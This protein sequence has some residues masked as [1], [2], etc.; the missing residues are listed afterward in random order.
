MSS[1]P[2]LTDHDLAILAEALGDSSDQHQEGLTTLK[3]KY[4]SLVLS[5]LYLSLS[6]NCLVAGYNKRVRRGES[7]VLYQFFHG[8]MPAIVDFDS[9]D[10]LFKS[11]SAF[12]D[13]RDVWDVDDIKE[14]FTAASNMLGR[15]KKTLKDWSRLLGV[16]QPVEEY[17]DVGSKLL[18]TAEIKKFLQLVTD[19]QD[20]NTDSELIPEFEGK[21]TIKNFKPSI[22]VCSSSG[23]GKTQLPF[24][25][26]SKVPLLY[27]LDLQDSSQRTLL[28][29]VYRPFTDI[30]L[31]FN[32]CCK[33]DRELLAT[34]QKLLNATK[35]LFSTSSTS[36]IGIQRP[37]SVSSTGSQQ[38]SVA[39][40][41]PVTLAESLEMKNDYFGMHV[42]TEI[43]RLDIKLHSVS[44]LEIVLRRM[45]DVRSG[46]GSSWIDC[47]LAIQIPTLEECF[48]KSIKE[49]SESI[50]RTFEIIGQLPIIFL[51]ECKTGR[52]EYMYAFKRNVIRMMNLIPVVM[53]TDT[54]IRNV[55]SSFSDADACS[56]AYGDAW[57]FVFSK[58]PNYSESLLELDINK[59]HN[60]LSHFDD[61]PLIEGRKRLVDMVK[62]VLV[63]ERPLFVKLILQD[64]RQMIICGSSLEEIIQSSLDF[65][66]STFVI[67]KKVTTE[68]LHS[69]AY[70][71]QKNYQCVDDKERSRIG[72]NMIHRHLGSL[73]YPKDKDLEKY[74]GILTLTVNDS[75][76]SLTYVRPRNKF[77]DF[78]PFGEFASF[79]DQ[80][81]S[82]LAFLSSHPKYPRPSLPG[83]SSCSLRRSALDVA[84]EIKLGEKNT[85]SAKNQRDGSHLEALVKC[86]LVFSLSRNGFKGQSA[87]EWLPWFASEYSSAYT[88][89]EFV[90]ESEELKSALSNIKLPFIGREDEEWNKDLKDFIEEYCEAE[91]GILKATSNPEGID[92]KILDLND[93]THTILRL[94]CKNWGKNVSKTDLAKIFW[95]LLRERCRLNLVVAYT[96]ED[97]AA[98]PPVFHKHEIEEN[99]IK[100]EKTFDDQNIVV[101]QVEMMAPP[102]KRTEAGLKQVK[103]KILYGKL[104]ADC[105]FFFVWP[106][107][108]FECL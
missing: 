54:K 59:L 94:E 84:D 99:D 88:P 74:K 76:L 98:M 33:K 82:H 40:Q 9:V 10:R 70:F 92:G 35:L 15:L 37:S 100:V 69:Q 25:I 83:N 79:E 43:A 23:M 73:E 78:H 96:F 7:E 72:S 22:F 65:I 5:E 17:E 38:L 71:A 81:F 47:E 12:K 61:L 13:L 34:N 68:F 87:V 32:D 105:R 18:E 31:V 19:V 89:F 104:T 80:P 66:F 28:Q 2:P 58:L 103:I 67:L 39:A 27:L 102:S 30:S 6:Y 26:A 11:I 90:Y 85:M 95:K 91:L 101:L 29:S 93:R 55:V 63:K 108:F 64:L 106:I 16:E 49:C 52:L 8:L 75:P 45:F 50:E 46:V 57:C 36:H 20:R 1:K 44:F 97:Y 77:A 56:S 107:E 60:E 3:K 53:G 14:A 21:L 4:D 62:K 41:E 86:S 48:A 24:T 51:D 42:M